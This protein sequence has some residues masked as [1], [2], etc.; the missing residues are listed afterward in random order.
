MPPRFVVI[1]A[2][3]KEVGAIRQG[4]RFYCKPQHTGFDIYDNDEKRR[5]KEDYP[6]RD[7]AE[8]ACL[9]LNQ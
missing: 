1:P 6:S 4:I 7:E 2:I 5:L 9:Q 8:K 3:P